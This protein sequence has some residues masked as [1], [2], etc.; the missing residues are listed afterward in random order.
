MSTTIFLGYPLFSGTRGPISFSN[1]EVNTRSL[2]GLYLYFAYLVAIGETQ[3]IA[4]DFFPD[5]EPLNIRIGEIGQLTKYEPNVSRGEMISEI[6]KEFGE[7]V[8]L[9]KPVGPVAATV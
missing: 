6:L 8:M 7:S 9:P 1:F 4:L 2:D 5:G 3:A